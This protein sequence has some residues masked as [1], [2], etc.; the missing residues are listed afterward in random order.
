VLR[1]GRIRYRKQ[2]INGD[3]AEWIKS[4][5]RMYEKAYFILDRFH[6]HKYIIAATSHLKDS[7]QE[8]RSEIYR[9][10]NG[11]RKRA[12]EA[13]FDK[14]LNVTESETKAK[15]VESSKNYSKRQIM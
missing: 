9:A 3:G 1:Y 6:M 12:A 11:K 14:I 5:S 10:I 13:A 2:N 4:G 15:A 8:A 7:V